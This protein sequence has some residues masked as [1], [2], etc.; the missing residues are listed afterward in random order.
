MFN[1]SSLSWDKLMHDS[2]ENWGKEKTL[3]DLIL[4]LGESNPS[5][6]NQN[7]PYAVIC[8]L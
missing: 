1:S 8:I 2:E 7:R 3:V 4:F 6:R 5:V